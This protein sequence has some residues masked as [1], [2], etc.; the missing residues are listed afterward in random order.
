MALAAE[1][2]ELLEIFQWL[3][4]DQSR[5]AQSDPEV[6]ARA[7]DELADVLIYLIRLADVLSIELES[8]V[9]DKIERNRARYPVQLSR[10][11]ATKRP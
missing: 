11:S 3:S 2:G 7:R 10:G 1:A 4:D 8:A 9:L 5:V 6:V